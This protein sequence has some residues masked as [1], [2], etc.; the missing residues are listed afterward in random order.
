VGICLAPA[1]TF[2]FAL[3]LSGSEH[4]GWRILLWAGYMTGAVLS[5]VNLRGHL[6]GG[7]TPHVWGWYI[8]PTP[9]YGVLTASLLLFLALWPE[10]VWRS[11]RHP[12]SSRQRV[13][14]KF[15]LLAGLIQIP[16]VLT[17]LLPIYGINIYPLGNLGNVFFT[18]IVAYAMVRHRLMD[19]DYIVRKG[20]SFVIAASMV[21]V[22]SGIV[23]A[24]ICRAFTMSTPLPFV[25]SSLAV[26]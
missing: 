14:A 2:H 11:Y 1:S 8:Q 21:L 26:T 13:Q 19:V 9:L 18:G 15:W 6:V 22:P 10:R 3:V 24:T 20:V 12:S 7:M 4:R 5:V 16:F 17:N 23:L 25:C